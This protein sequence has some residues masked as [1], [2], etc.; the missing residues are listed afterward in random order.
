MVE[1]TESIKISKEIKEKLDKNKIHPRETYNQ[2]IE[3]LLKNQKET[4]DNNFTQTELK[5]LKELASNMKII[6]QKDK[7]THWV[8]PKHEHLL[9]KEAEAKN[10]K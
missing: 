10:N 2:E 8:N 5:T 4:L 3:R 9:I 6:T 7:V 1:L